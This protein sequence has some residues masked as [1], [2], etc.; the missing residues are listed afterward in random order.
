MRRFPAKTWIK[1]PF[2]GIV[3]ASLTPAARKALAVWE[4]ATERFVCGSEANTMA[5]QAQELYARADRLRD[6]LRDTWKKAT[7]KEEEAFLRLLREGQ[8]K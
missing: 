6:E 1:P 3:E 2:G 7:E 8:K 5:V 4:E